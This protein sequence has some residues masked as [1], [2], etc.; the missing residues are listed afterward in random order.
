[1]NSNTLTIAA[2]QLCS[3]TC[4]NDN[5]RSSSQLIRNA[6]ENGATIIFTPEMT[7]LIDKAPGA[8][9][10]AAFN[11]ACD[12][13]LSAY[14]QLAKELSITLVIGSL[15]IKI[16]D[17]KCANRCFVLLPNGDIAY[18]YDKIH[19]FDV[20]LGSGG[21]FLESADYEAGNTAVVAELAEAK[22]GLSICY[23]LR[24]PALYQSLA[25]AGANIICVPAAFTAMTGKA[26]WEILLSARAI[27]TGAFIIAPAQGGVHEDGRHT[28]GHSMIINPWGE[29]IIEL[30]NTKV[31]FMCKEIDLK[32]VER[33]RHKLQN[34]QH[35]R[36]FTLN[37]PKA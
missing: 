15:P 22:L 32:E 21:K 4:I 12:P 1:M 37:V 33:A 6:A 19:M 30:A 18:R 2:I 36:P 16:S 23:D 11:E 29:I 31:D 28:Y 7:S 13:A 27:E 3:S 8:V 26:H 34:L 35:G 25:Q 5:I 24:F 9:I 14:R 10:A 20:N 17:N